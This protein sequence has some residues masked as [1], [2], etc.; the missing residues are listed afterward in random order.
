MTTPSLRIA[1]ATIAICSGVAATS[2]PPIEA[3]PVCGWSIASGNRLAADGMS[4][5]G[6]VPKPN[7]SAWSRSASA[8]SRTPSRANPALQDSA[9]MRVSVWLLP[10]LDDSVVLVPGSL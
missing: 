5:S 9:S 2:K 6:R 8:P 1:P 7:F 3:R 4:V 10:Q